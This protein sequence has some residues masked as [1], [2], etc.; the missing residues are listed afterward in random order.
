MGREFAPITTSQAS[1][2]LVERDAELA[3]R[4]FA[5]GLLRIEHPNRV[6]TADPHQGT[7]WL[8]E[9]DPAHLCWEYLPHL[10][11]YVELVEEYGYPAAAI[12]FETPDAELNLDLA[13]LDAAGRVQ[14]LGEVKTEPS[15]TRS[16]QT[17]VPTFAG[18]PGKPAPVRSGGPHG[19]HREAWKL[20]HQL[21]VTRAPYLWLA[22][23]GFRAA[24]DVEYD[25]HIVLCPRAH[26][27]PAGE[28]WPI[29]LLGL[30]PRIPA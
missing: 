12:R 29:E 19:A 4:G 24:F 14:V 8:V 10:A 17:L 27:P 15:Q 2:R 16:L 1:V 22:A 13:V 5:S 26:L 18:D 23:S 28:L 3:E 7:A 25:D 11:A 9:G 21:W 6:R 20:A 30:T